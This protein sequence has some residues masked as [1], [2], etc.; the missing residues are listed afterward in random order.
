MTTGAI[1]I[2]G[3]SMT[4]GSTTIRGGTGAGAITLTPGTAGTIVIGAAAGTGAITLGSSTGAQTINIGTGAGGANNQAVNIATTLSAGAGINT[5]TIGNTSTGTNGKNA[6]IIKAGNQS[7]STVAGN[8][9]GPQVTLGNTAS[10]T[11]VCSSLALA[12]SPTSG[13]AYELRDCSGAPAQDYAEFYPTSADADFGD[14]M[15]ASSEL[16]DQYREDG[17]GNILYSQPKIKVAKLIKSTGEYAA[18]VIGVVSNNYGDFTSTGYNVLNDKDHPMPVALNGRI[19]VKIATNS[20]EIHVGD[21][22]TTSSQSGRAMKATRAGYVIGKALQ[23]WNNNSDTVMVFVQQGYFNGLETSALSQGLS[24]SDVQLAQFIDM[25]AQNA[26]IAGTLTVDTIKAKNIE[27]INILAEKIQ[28]IQ[29]NIASL[30]SQFTQPT[31]NSAATSVNLE[32]SGIST[33]SADLNVKGK[34][35]FESVVEIISDLIVKNLEV[36]NLAT[37]LGNVIF[38]GDVLFAGRPTFNSDSAGFAVIRKGGDRV[39]IVF[40][41]EYEKSPVVTA[42]IS[43]TEDSVATESAVMNQGVSFIV[44]RRSTKGFSIILDKKADSDITFSWSALS[45]KDPHVFE[46]RAIEVT[47]TSAPSQVLGASSQEKESV[48]P[49]PTESPVPSIVQTQEAGESASPS[50]APSP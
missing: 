23:N 36:Q 31:N 49:A 15:V 39:D 46:S 35:V 13:T 47:P 25:N 16:V 50:A 11:A 10:T 43:L 3:G 5:V 22:I 18:H 17:K 34:S 9:A 32:T 14:V 29:D 24:G 26:N 19:P 28:V 12:T 44:S 1:T 48:T 40:E 8:S 21:F 37:F 45:I 4:S 6:V 30:S 27:G 2:G 33:I 41:K 38:K 7:G 20:P 42:S